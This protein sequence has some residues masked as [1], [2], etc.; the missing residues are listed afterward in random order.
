M[1]KILIGSI[2]IVV[3]A[4]AVVPTGALAEE[5]SLDD[6][7]RI[8]LQRSE[9]IK[10]S[11][12][13]LY[14]SKLGKEKAFSV[15]IPRL[16]AFGNYTR[17][18]ED[19]SAGFGVI[20]PDFATAWGMK[21]EQSFSLS[22]RE[23]TGLKMAEENIVR[24]SYD[25]YATREEYLFAVAGAYY[26]VLKA[27]K[28]LDIADSNL[29]RLTK[30]RNAAEKRLKVGEVTRTALLRAE[31]ELSGARSDQ[32][33]V[34]NGWEL[35]RAVLARIVGINR[36]FQLREAPR[37]EAQISSLTSLQETALAERAEIKSLESQK[38]IAGQ[39]IQYT[40]GTYWPELS[41]SGAYK[42][43]D[44]NPASPFLLKESTYGELSL[45]FPLFEGGLRRAEVREAKAKERQAGLFYEDLKKTIEIEVESA[46]L[47]LITQKGILKFLEDQLV[48]ARDNYYAVSKQFE[49]GLADSIDV[50]DANTLL[51]SAERKVAE[52]V[53][54]YQLSILRIK[55][56]TGVL[57]KTVIRRTS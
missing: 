3:I 30:H 52:A 14:I 25:L 24:N 8:A 31:G 4:L 55:R 41:V 9:R 1:K 39:Q 2:V 50:M 5:Y 10:V 53:Y 38:K 45:N 35:A 29:E 12:E 18:S 46:Y 32:L 22:G 37:E 7:Y 54:N 33:T 44:Q 6:L 13:N 34:K 15:L 43:A 40:K 51:V 17:Y 48:F 42:G 57:L 20:Q 27:K 28:I 21:L 23:L 47:D 26:D 19:K 11:E 16:S 56:V 49:F 36:D